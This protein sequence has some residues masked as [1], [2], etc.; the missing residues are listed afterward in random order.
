MVVTNSGTVNSPNGN[1]QVMFSQGGVLKSSCSTTFASLN[2]GGNSPQRS[3]AVSSGQTPNGAYDVTVIVDP[4][5]S[6]SESNENNNQATG[7][8]TVS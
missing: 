4:S 1:I 7:T 3:C 2:A 6:I 8:S 5:N